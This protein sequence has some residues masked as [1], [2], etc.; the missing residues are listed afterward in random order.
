M[1]AEEGHPDLVYKIVITEPLMVFL[2]SDHPPASRE[3]IQPSDFVGRTFIGLADQAPVVRTLVEHY[4]RQRGIDL[5]PAH[6]AEYISMLISLVA[7]TGGLAVSTRKHAQ[8][9]YPVS[10]QPTVG[11]RGAIG[12]SGFGLPQG[13]YVAGS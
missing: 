9:P 7:S 4:L 2:S 5:Q 1:R 11:W 13:Q 12:R 8:F 3:T 6:R 10:H